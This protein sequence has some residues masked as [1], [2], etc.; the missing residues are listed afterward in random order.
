[1]I[2]FSASAIVPIAYLV[3]V[4]GSL[5]IFSTVYRRRKA[6]QSVNIQPWFPSHR[7]RD[8]YLTLLHLEDPPCPPNLLKAALFER[9]TEDIARIY[10]LREAKMAGANLLQKG[11]ISEATFQQLNAAETETNM[12]C[13][14]VVNEARALGGAE[15]GETILA[16]ANEAYQKAQFLKIMDKSKK[17]GEEHGKKYEETKTILKEEKDKQRELALK[18]LTEETSL[19]NGDVKDEEANGGLD[20]SPDR[21]SKK[22]K[23]K[24]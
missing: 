22:K 17:Y 10:A 13:Q 5:G 12:E 9:A 1:M 3:L 18:E 23:N 14:D 6:Q 20:E 8:V 2:S 7:P 11:S 24:K 15:W 16:Q 4:L 21:K 19:T